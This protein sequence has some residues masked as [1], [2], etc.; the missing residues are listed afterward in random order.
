MTR[1]ARSKTRRAKA[2]EFGAHGV[3]VLI[4]KSAG[5]KVKLSVGLKFAGIVHRGCA[6]ASAWTTRFML[7]S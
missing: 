1:M 5:G 7:Q 4:L 6:T 2:D 3:Y